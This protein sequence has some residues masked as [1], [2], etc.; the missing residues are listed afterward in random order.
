MK[1]L[2]MT[3]VEW[4]VKKVKSKEFNDMFIWHKQ[5]IF[6]HAEDLERKQSDDYAI[7]FAEWVCG[8]CF[9]IFNNRFLYKDEEYSTKELLEIFKEEKGL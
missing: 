1:D 2:E 4:L 5:E 9:N 6:N 3:A 8:N 7:E